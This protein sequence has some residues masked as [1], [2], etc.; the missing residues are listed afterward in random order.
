[1]FDKYKVNAT[2]FT[3]GYIA[4]KLPE[5]VEEIVSKGHGIACHECSHPNV[6]RMNAKEFKGFKKVSGGI[7][8]NIRIKSP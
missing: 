3:I 6:K 8:K 4:E 5:L 7:G 2:L 1:L